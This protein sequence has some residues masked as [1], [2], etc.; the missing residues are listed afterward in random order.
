M[1]QRYNCRG[2]G[3]GNGQNCTPILL[4][5]VAEFSSKMGTLRVW[6]NMA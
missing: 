5:G 2:V 1:A 3:L 6:Q 4:V